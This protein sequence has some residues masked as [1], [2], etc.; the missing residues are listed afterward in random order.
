MVTLRSFNIKHFLLPTTG[1][2]LHART[3]QLVTFD[4]REHID[5]LPLHYLQSDFTLQGV[6]M[7]LTKRNNSPALEENVP[8]TQLTQKPPLLAKEPATQFVQELGTVP[9]KCDASAQLVH[10]LAP[11]FEKVP[12][13]H[14][15]HES[16]L[17]APTPVPYKPAPQ[18]WHLVTPL[19]VS[20]YPASHL[21]HT[22]APL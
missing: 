2:Q 20:K 1:E 10:E 11:P 3:G 17:P 12:A 13:A 4:G 18:I 5:A 21:M 6:H 8:E 14:V 15:K 16:E 22:L 9:V 19:P 7:D